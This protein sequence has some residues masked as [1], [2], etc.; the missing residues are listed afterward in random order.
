METKELA[1]M[2]GHYRP[3]ITRQNYEP[4]L[5]RTAKKDEEMP[6]KATQSELQQAANILDS[7]LKF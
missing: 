4:Y 2:L 7:L 5:P 1:R 6:D 3:S